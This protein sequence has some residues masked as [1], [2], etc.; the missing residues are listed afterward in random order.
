MYFPWTFKSVSEIFLKYGD[1]SWIKGLHSKFSERGILTQS[2]P[3]YKNIF[4]Y[5]QK[6]YKWIQQESVFWRRTLWEKAGGYINDNY[7]FM[8]DG[9]LWSRFFLYE[10]IWHINIP[11]GGLRQHGKRRAP[12]NMSVVLDEMERCI[13]HMLTKIPRDILDTLPEVEEYKRITS[14]GEDRIKSLRTS[15][16]LKILPYIIYQYLLANET[17]KVRK[18]VAKLYNV[19]SKHPRYNYKK[20][21]FSTSE[22]TREIDS[23]KK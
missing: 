5:A 3:V 1:V 10:D 17:N 12:N 18:K 21:I 6:D 15:K 19:I 11:I 20:I 7:R 22:I 14:K 13:D 2:N 9:E 8:V 23:V 16:V 4:D